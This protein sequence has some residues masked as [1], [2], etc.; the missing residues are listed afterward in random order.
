MAFYYDLP[1]CKKVIHGN[2]VILSGNN[3]LTLRNNTVDYTLEPGV[4]TEE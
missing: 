1:V 3:I 2:S 4:T